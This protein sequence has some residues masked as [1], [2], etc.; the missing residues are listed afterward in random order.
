MQRDK[1]TDIGIIELK[2]AKRKNLKCSRIKR[3]TLK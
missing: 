3:P 2:E 1:E